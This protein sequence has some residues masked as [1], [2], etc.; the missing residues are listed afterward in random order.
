MLRKLLFLL[1]MSGIT[2]SPKGTYAT[3]DEKEEPKALIIRG[4]QLGAADFDSA[5]S[6]P[7]NGGIKL[8][9]GEI[10]LPSPAFVILSCGDILLPPDTVLPSDT[11]LRSTEIEFQLDTGLPSGDQA[12]K[13]LQ[14]VY[15]VTALQKP[16]SYYTVGR[17]DFIYMEHVDYHH[18]EFSRLKLELTPPDVSGP[19]SSLTSI[20]TLAPSFK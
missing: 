15:Q 1:L 18:P 12:T 20:P 2:L 8:L 14:R 16:A 10:I 3:D 4:Y 17:G 6:L 13:L 11:G 5:V 7:S 19:S 9:S